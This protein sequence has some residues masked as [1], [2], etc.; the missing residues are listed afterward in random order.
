[1]TWMKIRF[2][3]EFR[4]FIPRANELAIITTINAIPDQWSQFNGDAALKFNG[5]IRN[6]APRIELVWCND[7]LRRTNG[8]T[9]GA[10]TAMTVCKW[11]I[12]RQRQIRV[13]FT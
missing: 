1:M 3:C 12:N 5:E 10:A 6:T 7:R 9:S 11:G 4:K 2:L 13:N 8:N